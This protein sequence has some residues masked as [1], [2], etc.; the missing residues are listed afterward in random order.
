MPTLSKGRV[1]IRP[2]AREDWPAFLAAVHRSHDLHHPWVSPPSTRKAFGSYLERL[3]TDSHRGF[4]V[5]HRRTGDLVGVIN[6]N[7][8]IRGPLQNAFLGYYGFSPH[9]GTGQMHEGMLLVLNHAFRRP[10]APRLRWRESAA[11]FGRGTPG[12]I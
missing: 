6:L 7:H 4:L 1:I 12:A 3:G 9:A 11:L 5:L 2:P 8:L 10:T